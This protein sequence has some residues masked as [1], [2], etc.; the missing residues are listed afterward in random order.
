MFTAILILIVV[1]APIDAITLAML[2][3]SIANAKY[4]PNMHR[5]MT[6]S[7]VAS[8]ITLTLIFGYR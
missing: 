8:A 3:N 7:G 2:F 5:W 1:T 4:Y 6:I